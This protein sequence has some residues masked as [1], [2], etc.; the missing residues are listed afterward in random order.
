MKKFILLFVC[1]MFICG[2]VIHAQIFWSENFE[3][4]STTG[5]AASSYSGWTTASTGTN[6]ANANAWYVSC[7]E[8]GHTDGVCGSGCAAVSTTATLATLHLGSN[9]TLGGDA[10]ATYNA[11]GLCGIGICVIT[12]QRAES[13]TINC[14][15]KTGITLSFNYIENG[16]GTTDD[17]TVWYYDGSAWSLLVN[18][19]KT[20]IG[21]CAPQ[22]QW[23]HYSIALPAS[24]DNNAN[25]KIGFNWTNNDDGAGSDPSFAVDSM[26]LSTSGSVGPVVPGMTAS[27]TTICKDSCIT[28]TNTSTG[29]VDSFRWVGTNATIAAP[30]TSPA[31]AC[32]TVAGTQT[33]KLYLY[34]GGAIVDS[35]STAITVNPA[36]APTITASGDTLSVP[37][38]YIGY[39][40]V[41]GTTPIPG[42]TNPTYVY[43]VSGVYWVVVDSGGCLGG[44]G[45]NTTAVENINN[46]RYSFRVVQTSGSTVSIY[47]SKAF[48]ENLDI[49][50]Y[51]VTGR[52]YRKEQW[53]NGKTEKPIGDLFLSK[54]LYMIR[55]SNSE[56][57]FVLKWLKE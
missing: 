8:N 21:S 19:P 13:P 43:T 4:G 7:A 30:L 41:N 33:V 5:M 51:D 3:S 27:L 10:G 15:G 29:T 9:A 17:A 37:A 28:L 45:Y 46:N 53:E 40:W 35:A 2:S 23:T 57:S 36:P 48:P 42:A 49:S 50:I 32:F 31:T 24:A 14:T 38:V 20:P 34:N 39:Q 54:G 26:A 44:A 1:A 16:Q 25:V 47:C 52:V 55:L 6:D 22:G 11:G 18:P 12:N 56:N